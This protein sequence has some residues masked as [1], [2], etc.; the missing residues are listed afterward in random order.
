MGQRGGGL[1]T[2]REG[3]G[4]LGTARVMSHDEIMILS[5]VCDFDLG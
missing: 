1:G 5:K 2:L 4:L 3:G